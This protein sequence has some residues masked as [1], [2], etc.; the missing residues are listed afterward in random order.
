GSLLVP[1]VVQEQQASVYTYDLIFTQVNFV[2][3][4]LKPANAM[5]PLKPLIF[6]PDALDDSK[7]RNGFAA[8]WVD[9]EKQYGYGFA[10]NV[11][12]LWWVNTDLVK[13]GEIKSA[14]DLLDPKWRG[15]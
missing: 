11:S 2:W 15:K 1:K 5:D 13:D 8:G 6:H 9:P 4:S 14:K 12:M 7:W 10:E 3:P